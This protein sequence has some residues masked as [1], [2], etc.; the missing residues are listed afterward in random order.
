MNIRICKYLCMYICID[1][2]SKTTG[3]QGAYPD[4]RVGRR[5]LLEQ[6]RPACGV[7]ISG[8]PLVVGAHN[9]GITLRCG[10]STSAFWPCVL[11]GWDL[12]SR[13]EKHAFLHVVL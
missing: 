4:S 1:I 13:A 11:G 12:H 10:G 7:L 2:W 5:K 3:W 6:D 9:A 8:S